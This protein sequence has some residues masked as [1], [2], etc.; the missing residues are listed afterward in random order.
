M[1]STRILCYEFRWLCKYIYEKPRFGRY[2]SKRNRRTRRM[3]ERLHSIVPS[4]WKSTELDFSVTFK[5]AADFYRSKSI[6]LLKLGEFP[7]LQNLSVSVAL[8][9]ARIGNSFSSVLLLVSNIFWN[10]VFLHFLRVIE[11]AYRV[12]HGRLPRNRKV[13]YK[14]NTHWAPL[15]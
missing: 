10:K 13:Q 3:F 7:S 1:Y 6:V 11:C 12:L 14:I 4:R 15:N 2:A 9:H 5:L 8:W